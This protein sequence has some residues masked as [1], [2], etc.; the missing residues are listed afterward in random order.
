[1]NHNVEIFIKE[2]D[3]K[4]SVKA[5]N[6]NLL[7]SYEMELFLAKTAD[8]NGKTYVETVRDN[9]ELIKNSSEFLKDTLKLNNKQVELVKDMDRDLTVS[10]VNRII[11]RLKGLSDEDVTKIQE[12]VAEPEKK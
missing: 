8:T 9:I 4:F 3:K 10:I 12:E 7:K 1:M 2:F 6:R 11:L 5:S